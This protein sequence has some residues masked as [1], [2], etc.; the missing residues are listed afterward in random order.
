[1]SDIRCGMSDIL[2]SMMDN[3]RK[4][5][6]L[7]I[8]TI[9]ASEIAH[10]LEDVFYFET[11]F[12]EFAVSFHDHVYPSCILQQGFHLLQSVGEIIIERN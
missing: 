3:K 2:C 8:E 9:S 7:N 4:D 5:G 1:M 6:I 10:S 12:E 11:E